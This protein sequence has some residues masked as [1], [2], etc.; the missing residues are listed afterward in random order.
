MEINQFG[1]IGVVMGGD[2]CER[3]ISLNSGKAVYEALKESGVDVA[4]I[5][6]K[7]GNA[8][9]NISLIKSYEI[10]CAFL[11]VHGGF[12]EDGGLQKLLEIIKIPYTGS[13]AEA[14]RLAMDKTASRL[15][16]ESKNLKVPRYKTID[17]ASYNKNNKFNN[18]LGTPLVIKPA[19][20]GS[21]LGLSIIDREEDLEKAVELAFAF[22]KKIVIEEYIEGREVTVGILGAYPL[23]V[24]EIIPKKRFFDYEA[25]YQSGATDYIVPAKLEKIIAERITNAALSAHEF[26]GCSGCSRVDIILNK[27]DLPVIL[28]V[29]T[30]PGFTQTSL[31]PKAAKAA[32]IGFSELCLRLIKLVYE[33]E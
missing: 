28:E 31:L 24:I 17:K 14:S 11:A 23:P 3:E 33:K 7:S 13:K 25:K 19:A 12:G 9:G 1:R 21:S 26:L 10:D 5:D 29:N 4:A 32:G 8:D 18:S 16:F 30:I 6:I 22:D 2:S 15:V 20:Q 27:E